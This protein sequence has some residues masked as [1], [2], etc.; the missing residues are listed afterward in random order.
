MFKNPKLSTLQIAICFGPEPAICSLKGP[1]RSDK[2]LKLLTKTIGT[3]VAVA[4]VSTPEEC[5]MW[6]NNSLFL[7]IVSIW[8]V[9]VCIVLVPA[10]VQHIQ[11][12]LKGR[13]GEVEREVRR[14][15][16]RIY[17]FTDKPCT[18]RC[19]RLHYAT[20]RIPQTSRHLSKI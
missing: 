4:F 14:E 1:F 16:D 15:Q 18:A 8:F 11:S 19:A 12:G 20:S 10:L 17:S 5:A 3:R 6:N 9:S 7:T 2:Q 13:Y